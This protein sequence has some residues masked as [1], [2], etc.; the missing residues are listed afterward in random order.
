MLSCILSFFTQR[1]CSRF[2][3][4]L[5]VG[6]GVCQTPSIRNG[7]KSSERGER[8]DYQEHLILRHVIGTSINAFMY[9]RARLRNN[10]YNRF[11]TV[12]CQKYEKGGTINTVLSVRSMIS[13]LLNNVIL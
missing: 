2:K 12:E 3:I 6:E 5:K 4:W 1:P 8:V 7:G 13:V 9:V 11:V 10:M